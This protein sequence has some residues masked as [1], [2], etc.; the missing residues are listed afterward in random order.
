MNESYCPS[1]NFIE[2]WPFCWVSWKPR[3]TENPFLNLSKLSI[4]VMHAWN[5]NKICWK[6]KKLLLIK[7]RKDGQMD[8][9]RVYYRASNNCSWC[10]PNY[11]CDTIQTCLSAEHDTPMPTGQDAPCRGSL[12]TLTSW[13]KYLPPN[14]APIPILCVSLWISCSSS[15]SLKARP[16]FPP[17][18]DIHWLWKFEK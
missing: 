5:L 8:R 2:W 12:T 18:E 17:I 6:W 4:K 14:W 9:Y 15:R 13:Q 3:L 10:G 16:W 1:K 7:E 11:S